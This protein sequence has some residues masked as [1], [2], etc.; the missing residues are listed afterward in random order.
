MK[1]KN[2][3]FGTQKR[4]SACHYRYG[5]G[6]GGTVTWPVAQCL[7]PLQGGPFCPPCKMALGLIGPRKKE[8]KTGFDRQLGQIGPRAA[9]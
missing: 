5:G 4:D 7:N 2:N 8:K 6:I 3:I 9:C 1:I